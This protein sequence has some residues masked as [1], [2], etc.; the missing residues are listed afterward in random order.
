M[1]S[2]SQRRRRQANRRRGQK[3]GPQTTDPHLQ[4]VIESIGNT[5]GVMADLLREADPGQA[6]EE[7]LIAII[8][9]LTSKFASAD[10][11]RIIEVARLACLPWSW[12][13]AGG[14]EGGPTRAELIALLAVMASNTAT[15]T[16]T[17]ARTHLASS[18]PRAPVGDQTPEP[19]GDAPESN[20]DT[21]PS[22]SGATDEPGSTTTDQGVTTESADPSPQP[23]TDMVNQ[24][25]PNIDTLLQ[26]AQIR[27]LLQTEEIDA[28]GMIAARMRSAEVWIRNTSYPDMVK[29]TLHQLFASDLEDGWL[30][31]WMTR[32]T[33]CRPNEVEQSARDYLRAKKHQLSLPRGVVFLYD[34][35]TSELIN[36]IY[37]GHVGELEPRL[38]EKLAQLKPAD[39]LDKL[40]HP[41]GKKRPGSSSARGRSKNARKKK[42]R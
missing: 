28:L 34:E 42:R 11:P 36:V 39:H 31:V 20:W 4:V 26:L 19:P 13:P 24:A 32:P 3:N 8:D 27:E 30:L 22:A 17:P 14:A 38:K 15:A 21:S 29:T 2:R 12:D 23:L 1:S 10:P 6:A 40:S 35:G 5:F 41:G 18:A 25:L 7:Q 9:D 33:S 16:G 37:D